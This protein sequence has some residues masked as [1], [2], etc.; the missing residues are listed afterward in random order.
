MP[1]DETENLRSS[2]TLAAILAADIAGDSALMSAD[3][4]S[5]CP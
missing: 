2:R 5:Y 4:G 3:E 1:T